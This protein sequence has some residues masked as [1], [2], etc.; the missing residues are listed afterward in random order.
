[1]HSAAT[2][3]ESAEHRRGATEFGERPDDAALWLEE[4][5]RGSRRA[6]VEL[7]RLVVADSP[8]TAGEDHD[9]VRV[10]AESPRDLPPILVHSTSMR[11]I[12]GAHRVRAAALRGESGVEA[13]MYDG[14]EE[15]IFVL[16]VRMNTHHGLPLDRRDRVRAANRI[17]ETHPDWSDRMIAS[18]VGLATKTVGSLRCRSTANG[19]QS[20]AR[21][22]RDGR[23]RPLDGSAGRLR[24]I[25]VLT[26]RPDASVRD[27]ACAAGISV[28]TAQD[29]R[30]RVRAGLNPVPQSDRRPEKVVGESASS[31]E[32]LTAVGVSTTPG[33]ARGA[34]P[35]AAPLMGLDAIIAQL[36]RDPSLRFNDTG[37]TLVRLLEKERATL[38]VSRQLIGDAPEHCADSL[39]RIARIY[40]R[41]WESV[42][43][44]LLV[45]SHTVR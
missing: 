24:A 37:R 19:A 9:H 17:L 42:A 16:A 2:T 7:S 36:C 31:A 33:A 5:L 41:A 25:E 20:N 28:S 4:R 45:R 29:V 3:S 18:V 27:V 14:D 35:G 12:D 6:F 34:D 40:S 23:S 10:L 26:Q 21:V 22:G 44:E 13:I 1:M 11:V 39:I 15:D 30:R 43:R 32:P 38:A 8:R